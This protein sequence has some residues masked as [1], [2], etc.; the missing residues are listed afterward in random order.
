VS[1]A[2]ITT[3]D[4]PKRA[5]GRQRA[6]FRA[7]QRV[8]AIPVANDL[9]LESAGQTQVARE[10]LTRVA[11]AVPFGPALLF[12][13]VSWTATQISRVMVT[14]RSLTVVEPVFLS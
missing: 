5:D 7:A 2:E 8:L 3:G 1:V 12:A 10:G 13:R 14:S 6:R 9:P 4:H 11:A